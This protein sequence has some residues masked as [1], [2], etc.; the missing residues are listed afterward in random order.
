GHSNSWGIVT[1]VPLRTRVR[2]SALKL[3]GIAGGLRVTGRTRW[4]SRRLLILCYHG[5]ALDDEHRWNPQLYVPPAHLEKRL[6]FL[7]DEGYRVLPLNEAV[8]RLAMGNLPPK[9]VVITVDD[10]TYDFHSVAYPIFQRHQ[11]PVTVYVTSYYVF[12]PRPVFDVA[13]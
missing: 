8:T 2:D 12:D 4:R 13:A 5:F 6:V 9:A 7:K 1:R 3:I 10:G 11:V